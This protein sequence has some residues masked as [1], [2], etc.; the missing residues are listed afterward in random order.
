MNRARLIVLIVGALIAVLLLVIE[1]EDDAVPEITIDTG[2]ARAR[3][4]IV[5][6]GSVSMSERVALGVRFEFIVEDADPARAERALIAARA[7]LDELDAQ[8]RVWKPGSALWT[9]N[10]RAGHGTTSISRDAYEL[11]T[12]AQALYVQTKGLY[13]PTIGAVSALWAFDD[14]SQPLPD[15]A[16]LGRALGR[17]HGSR[18]RLDVDTASLPEAG[19]R[20]DLSG[21]E[22]AYALSEI[23][24]TLERA[25]VQGA[26]IRAGGDVLTRGVVHGPHRVVTIEN[27]RW[28]DQAAEH[29][30]AP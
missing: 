15:R 18:L 29:F 3:P 13:D 14:P 16:A 22:A 20:L 5:R 25:G 12:R 2:S 28:P 23:M 24:D 7:R 1:R 11:L 27:P 17:V 4:V 21:L 26:M 30:N 8:L 19:M 10:A 9:I 6:R